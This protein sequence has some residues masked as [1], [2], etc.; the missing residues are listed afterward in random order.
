MSV[1]TIN[2]FIVVTWP[3]I[4]INVYFLTYVK[5]RKMCVVCVCDTQSSIDAVILVVSIK[6][7]LLSVSHR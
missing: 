6:F 5:L 3:Y 4:C 7:S 2:H 1:P